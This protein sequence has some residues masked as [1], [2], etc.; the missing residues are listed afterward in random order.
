M[1]RGYNDL[2]VVIK[3]QD[4]KDFDK[5]VTL[6]TQSKGIITCIARGVRRSVSKRSSHIDLLNNVSFQ[7][8][9]GGA[10][11]LGEIVSHNLYLKI[12]S[13][14]KK[15]SKCLSF[16]EIINTLVPEEVP[17]RELYL[18]LNNFLKKMDSCATQEEVDTTSSSFAK[19]L[20]RHL[21][22]SETSPAPVASISSYFEFL[23]NKKIIGKE[24]V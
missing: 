14:L 3:T 7:I 2:G 5:L 15:V 21:G 6:C 17:D 24:I 20:L 12:K 10:Y 23:M 18:S 11:F 19:Y 9:E 4:Y 22:Y 8:H 16:L 1:P 13:D